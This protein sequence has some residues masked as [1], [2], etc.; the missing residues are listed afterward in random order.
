MDLFFRVPLKENKISQYDHACALLFFIVARPPI[1]DSWKGMSCSLADNEISI[2]KC[3]NTAT[4]SILG[5]LIFLKFIANT[6]QERIT[7]CTATATIR[8]SSAYRMTAKRNQPDAP[9]ENT[10]G[11]MSL[12]DCERDTPAEHYELW[13]CGTV[14]FMR[15]RYTVRPSKLSVSFLVP[16]LPSL[17][18]IT[19]ELTPIC[20]SGKSSCYPCCPGHA[21]LHVLNVSS[22]DRHLVTFMCLVPSRK[23]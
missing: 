16:T 19:V 9:P 13:K 1:G 17:H 6:C 7:K 4:E 3:I 18:V 21:T 8:K 11:R 2:R 15:S 20:S 10:A 22:P 23:H 14:I 5:Y 12:R